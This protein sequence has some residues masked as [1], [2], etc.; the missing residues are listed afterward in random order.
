MR[1]TKFLFARE[2]RVEDKETFTDFSTDT[3]EA[4]VCVVVI[5]DVQL[6]E[7]GVCWV[8]FEPKL[9]GPATCQRRFS[10]V[11]RSFQ[12]ANL[13]ESNYRL[14]SLWENNCYG[15][16]GLVLTCHDFHLQDQLSSEQISRQSAFYL[17]CPTL[18][19]MS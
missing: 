6:D 5:G 11:W 12:K 14:V 8:E 3:V 15:L 17:R 9:E 7:M 13:D 18:G 2:Y 4:W 10:R 1:P 19:Y 16:F